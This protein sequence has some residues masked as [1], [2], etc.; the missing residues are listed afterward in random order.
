MCSVVRMKIFN[1]QNI[2]SILIIMIQ[3]KSI[4]FI[5]SAYFFDTIWNY[6][7]E[8]WIFKQKHFR[9]EISSQRILEQKLL[10]SL[11]PISFWSNESIIH[12]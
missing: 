4:G 9:S 11:A 5:F 10:L 6:L 8:F 2:G 3:S 7:H 12:F 1:R